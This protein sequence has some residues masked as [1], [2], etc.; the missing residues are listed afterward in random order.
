[1]IYAWM[2][3]AV[4]ASSALVVLLFLGFSGKHSNL[5]SD[6]QASQPSA[7]ATFGKAFLYTHKMKIVRYVICVT[8]CASRFRKVG[9]GAC[10]VPLTE[11]IQAHGEFYVTFTS[12]LG[13]PKAILCFLTC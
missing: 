2:L 13:S 8:L 6:G 7:Y 12:P 11:R 3:A 5:G 1:M 10:I 4:I 9:A